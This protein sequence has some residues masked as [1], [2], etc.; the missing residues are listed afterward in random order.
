V[1][2]SDLR[3]SSK[4]RG[5]ADLRDA[6][7]VMNDFMLGKQEEIKL[8]ANFDINQERLFYEMSITDFYFHLLIKSKQKDG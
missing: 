2:S 6:R 3:G 1:C 8:L 5:K 4:V 7:A